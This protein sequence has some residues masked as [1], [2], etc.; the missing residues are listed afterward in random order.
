V[1]LSFLIVVREG[2]ET[3][4]FLFARRRASSPATRWGRGLLGLAAAVFLASRCTGHGSPE[5]AQLLQRHHVLLI[6]FAAGLLAHGVHEWQEAALLPVAIEHLWDMNGV[7]NESST[8]GEFMKAVFGYNG[9]P[10]LVEVLSYL[11]YV[12]LA[13]G[14]TSAGA[15]HA[16]DDRRALAPDL[17]RASKTPAGG[18][19]SSHA[20]EQARLLQ[21]LEPAERE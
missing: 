17:R 18:P 2:I 20:S 11:G 8:V 6:L 19:G 5:P 16:H 15:G 12:V 4:L 13:G 10:S 9:N 21:P 7:L 1:S 14:T 3:A